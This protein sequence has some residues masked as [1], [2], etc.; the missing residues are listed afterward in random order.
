[1]EPIY[2]ERY[3]DN[4]EVVFSNLLD[5]DWIQRE[6]C[7]RE[8]YWDTKKGNP[9]TYGKGMGIRT[10]QPNK[11][12]SDVDFIRNKLYDDYGVYYDGCFLNK[13]NKDKNHLGWHADDD[14]GI[15][16]SKPIAVISFG[17]ERDINWKEIG[18]KGFECISSQLLGQGSLFLMPAGMQSTH[19]HRI[20]K[21][22]FPVD[23]RI[24]MTFRALL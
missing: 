11:P 2:K 22:P 19:Y 9:Y 1:M 18:S 4:P 17:Q 3:I 13:Y 14:L 21:S 6:N 20:P 10:Y 8:E 12:S 24:S 7:P 23:I 15:D 5:L 16:H